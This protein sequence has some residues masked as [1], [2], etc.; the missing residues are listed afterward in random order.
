MDPRA[1]QDFS[2]ASRAVLGFLHRRLGFDLWMVTRTEGD[3]WIVLDCEDH[4]YGVAPG[5]V[6]RWADSFCYEMV[7]GRGPNIAPASND[8]PAYAAAPIGRQIDIKAYVGIPLKRADGSLFGTL[9]GIDPSEQSTTIV[10]ERDLI[11]LLGALLS[12]L[13]QAELKAAEEARRAERL[14]AESM[15]DAL[16]HLYNRRG[17]ETLLAQEEIRCR[18]Y[19][20]SAAIVFADL[21][22][23]KQIND[24]QGHA[25]GD[26]VIA[27]VA[28]VLRKCVRENDI[29]ARLGGDEF[30]ILS[31]E[32]ERAGADALL[33]RVRGAMAE[34]GIGLSLG[35]AM[36]DPAT[37]LPAACKA[38]DRRMYE[39]KRARKHGR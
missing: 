18:R 15:T 13:L 6:F 38:A 1:F 33:K 8:I 36:R 26:E 21:D 9:C 5:S 28:D 37:G 16:T 24:R 3:D 4:G 20:H 14:A 39:D 17:W 2:T 10:E 11:E 23:L 35:M 34:A 25:A 32:C 27:R 22:D 7:R 29:V 12:A 30:G 31:V 19:G